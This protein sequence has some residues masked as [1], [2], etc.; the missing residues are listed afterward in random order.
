MIT[1]LFAK[2]HVE[3]SLKVAG[4]GG[5]PCVGSVSNSKRDGL[6]W[7]GNI[8]GANL[9]R[10]AARLLD[11]QAASMVARLAKQGLIVH[12]FQLDELADAWSM[13]ARTTFVD[14]TC[15]L[16]KGESALLDAITSEILEDC[17]MMSLQLVRDCQSIL[18]SP[19]TGDKVT[20]RFDVG[21][22]LV[23]EVA[24]VSPQL[25]YNPY[26]MGSLDKDEAMKIA[27]HF[28]T[29]VMRV[30]DLRAQ[31]K[32]G[33]Q[34]LATRVIHNITEHVASPGV[35]CGYWGYSFV[36]TDGILDEAFSSTHRYDRKSY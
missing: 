36:L 18:L 21:E 23:V 6:A 16:T 26:V 7:F 27:K 17:R 35:L 29:G 10:L 20:S 12:I 25:D 13:A 14:S 31:V 1:T 3:A 28:S 24:E 22:G 33:D 32:F 34:V 2:S 11:K 9:A 4:Y 5:L 15:A 8:G 19:A 30:F